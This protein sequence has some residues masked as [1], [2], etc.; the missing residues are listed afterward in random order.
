[1]FRPAWPCLTTII[2][3]LFRG[4][5][6]NGILAP[7]NMRCGNAC[8]GAQ[9]SSKH[10]ASCNDGSFCN[11][12]FGSRVGT[13]FL[14]YTLLTSLKKDETAFH[15]CDPV[16]SVLV[17]LQMLG[18]SKC[19]SHRISLAVYWLFFHVTGMVTL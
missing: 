7:R 14:R 1:M 11:L 13:T 5:N 17:M 4:L 16:L 9:V 12:C 10:G 6:S 19:L 2:F 15:C 8:L 3:L 18:V